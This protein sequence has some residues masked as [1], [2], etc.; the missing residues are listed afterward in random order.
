MSTKAEPRIDNAGI[1]KMRRAP[2]NNAELVP[3]NLKNAVQR[4]SAASVVEIDRLVA[5]L[6]ALRDRLEDEGRRVQR[7]IVDYSN[8]SQS[9][10]RSTAAVDQALDQV[11]ALVRLRPTR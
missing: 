1:A 4:I 10:A 3:D 5:D 7:V 11:R 8:L 2:E 6:E 9:A